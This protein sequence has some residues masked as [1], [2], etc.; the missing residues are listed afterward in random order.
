MAVGVIV[1]IGSICWRETIRPMQCRGGDL[2]TGSLAGGGL[3]QRRAGRNALTQLR[4]VHGYSPKFVCAVDIRGCAESC[5]S[6]F[7]Q[8]SPTREDRTRLE[9]GHLRKCRSPPCSRLDLETA[10]LGGSRCQGAMHWP[11]L[12]D[13]GALSGTVRASAESGS[14]A[15]GASAARIGPQRCRRSNPAARHIR[16]PAREGADVGR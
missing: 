13:P 2:R 16:I 10:I 12:S 6:G 15:G 4:S 7:A 11:P 3:R 9:K 14:V 8:C 1:A 5:L